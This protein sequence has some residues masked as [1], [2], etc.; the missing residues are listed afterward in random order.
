MAYFC[1]TSL[2]ITVISKVQPVIVMGVSAFIQ[3]ELKRLLNYS[4]RL[5]HLGYSLILL[6][7]QRLRQALQVMARRIRFVTNLFTVLL[8]VQVTELLLKAQGGLLIH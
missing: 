4:I 7:L 8:A 3:E 6:P 1:P 2:Y 5:P